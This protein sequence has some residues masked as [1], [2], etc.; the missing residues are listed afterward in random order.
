MSPM[1]APSLAGPRHRAL[2]ALVAVAALVL[3][4]VA[5]AGSVRPPSARDA[6]APPAGFSAARA[7]QHVQAIATEP[8]P[9]GSAAQDRV[10]DHLMSTLTG[11]GLTPEVQDTVS[12]Q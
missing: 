3:V 1:S 5:A 10:R 7:F 6:S 11:L 4:G 2:A 8:H 12:V 9:V